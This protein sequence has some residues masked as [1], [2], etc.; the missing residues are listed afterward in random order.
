MPKKTHAESKLGQ[1][2]QLHCV[3]TLV[4]G[5]YSFFKSYKEAR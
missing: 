1:N 3:W 5:D 4:K 2:F